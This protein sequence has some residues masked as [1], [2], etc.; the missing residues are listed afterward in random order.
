[1]GVFSSVSNLYPGL[2]GTACVFL[3]AS[4]RLSISVNSSALLRSFISLGDL[5]KVSLK[6]RSRDD[7]ECERTFDV[8]IVDDLS[9]LVS[10]GVVGGLS[11]SS[12]SSSGG[13][14]KINPS[15]KL[16][17]VGTVHTR[18]G[19]Q[20][21]WSVD[22]PLISMSSSQSPSSVSVSGYLS[23]QTKAINF[24]LLP[25]A[26]QIQDGLSFVLT[27]SYMLLVDGRS[28]SSSVTIVSNLPPGSCLLSISP[29][30]G[31][32][33]QTEFLMSSSHCMDEDLPLSYQF[34]YSSSLVADAVE[35]VVLRSKM[36]LSFAST[37]LPSGAVERD[38]SLVCVSRVFDALDSWSLASSDVTVRSVPMSLSDLQS[39]VWGGLNASLSSLDVDNLRTVI[40]SSASVLN[41]VNCSLAP[42]IVCRSMN[43]QKC[44]SLSGTC[45]KC[46]SGSVG[47]VGP[48]NTPCLLLGD[49]ATRRSLTLTHQ[50]LL[51]IMSSPSSQSCSSDAN[52]EVGLFLE[53]N[54]LSNRCEPI[55]QSCPNSCS[56]HGKCVLVSKYDAS[57][58]VSECGV[59]DV[60]C[61]PRCECEEAYVGSSSCSLRA[62]EASQ[63]IDIRGLLIE[64]VGELMSKDNVD[65]SSVRSWLRALS[66]IGSDW[67]SLS[68]SAKRAMARLAVDILRLSREVGLSVEDLTESG[69][70]KVLDLCVSG[71]SSQS[72]SLLLS[73]TYADYDAGF[74]DLSLLELLLREHSEFVTTD[75]LEAQDLQSSVSPH[76]RSSSFFFSSSSSPMLLSIPS[77]DLESFAKSS[78]SET[79]MFSQQSVEI[80]SSLLAPL[81]VTISETLNPL[82][83]KG[84]S[85]SIPRIGSIVNE[86]V[87]ESQLSLPLY[88]TLGS[89]PCQVNMS[90]V[91]TDCSLRATMQHPLPFPSSTN[92]G[93]RPSLSHSVSDSNSNQTYFETDCAAGVVEDRSFKC[94]SGDVVIIS[95][96]GSS[97]PLRG[98]RSCPVRSTRV[99]C[100]AQVHSPSLSPSVSAV[101]P[102][103]GMISCHLSDHNS[104]ISVCVCN[105]SEVRTIG[106]TVGPVSFS[107]L[108]IERSV[109]SDFVSTWESASDLSSGDVSGSWVVLVTV[110]GIGGVFVLFMLL[111]IYVDLSEELELSL[112]PLRG[113]VNREKKAAGWWFVGISPSDPPG[114]S[115]EGPSMMQL[116]DES[117]PSVFQCTSLWTKFKEE[118][119]VYHR[120]LGIVLHY[121]PE[122]SRSMRLLS[123]FS[124]IVI[125]LFV[126]SVTYNIADPDDGSCEACKSESR[127]LSLS[128]TLN[129]RQSRCFWQPVSSKIETATEDG[130][131]ESGSCH[132]R[133]IGE[134]M[135]RMFI[136]ALISAI[137]S[138]PFAL[139]VQYLIATVLS[140]E[141]VDKAELEEHKQ[142]LEARRTQ[143][144]L[145]QRQR[146]AVTSQNLV[147]S[148]GRSSL[149]DYNNLQRELSEYHAQ[150]K[151]K[152]DGAT[153]AEEFRGESDPYWPLFSFPFR[154]LGL[155]CEQTKSVT[156][157]I[158]LSS[159]LT[160]IQCTSLQ[161]RGSDGF[162]E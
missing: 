143:L 35:I 160:T 33:L 59:L 133:E 147:E 54:Q 42:V 152:E 4:S 114:H 13:V 28:V 101:S 11:S 48:S 90:A 109:V 130:G 86:S 76:L 6:G 58:T 111:G 137:V 119:K 110:G 155:S 47:V 116:V 81:R 151:K 18:S 129:M 80:F 65:A 49:L 122:F 138:A 14:V 15:S 93:S 106:G 140:R 75:M 17:V 31:E 112:S 84:V 124:G 82:T 159:P 41:E 127:C 10:V 38:F 88:V 118:M 113:G 20:V 107:I 62:K 24:I 100:Q 162:D 139:S 72:S 87:T 16:K 161:Q 71:L 1:M 142:E 128:S 8:S 40:A 63:A 5:F 134:D 9:P 27:L 108:S 83:T 97:S 85:R 91:I 66:L 103:R 126:Q 78:G 44:G 136:V 56:G 144:I 22:N 77:T 121:S 2:R 150:L 32:M 51:T 99:E 92:S 131:S 149:E 43:R 73:I 158:N 120:W 21:A 36:E 53:C 115:Q 37:T 146:S 102:S 117:L 74:D 148:C 153:E 157:K 105:L 154:L 96:N 46:V 68:V 7:R 64:N 132:F 50:R 104:S 52:C 57:V 89:L 25:A 67:L 60:S 135:T 45:G 23:S 30:S 34:G 95:C 70:I 123:L 29:V 94:P 79:A 19:G 26:L 125:M 156:H 39:Y 3:S 12:P 98:R 141:T 61:V 69:L 145:S 55:Q